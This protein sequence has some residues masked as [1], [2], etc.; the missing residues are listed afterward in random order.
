MWEFHLREI[1]DLESLGRQFDIKVDAQ[2][3]VSILA[4]PVKAGKL[5]IP[6][7]LVVHPMEGCD[8][9]SQGGPGEL[10]FRR[11][12][13]F[14]SGGAGLIWFEA[15]A[16]V[17][18]ARAN[19]RQLWINENSKD[20]FAELV[21]TTKRAAV[22]SMGKDHKPV[23]VLQLTHSGRYSKPEGV[24]CPIAAQCN[25]YLYDPGISDD[26]T[27]VSDDYLD[28]L[29]DSFVE[30]AKLAFEVGFDAVDIK[31]CHGY[32]INELLASYN[33]QGKYGGS[34][35]NRT[36]FLLEVV[37][38]IHNNLG[39]EAVVTTRLGVYDGIQYPYGWG[40]DES[41]YSKPDL[42]EPKK[43][44]K[45]LQQR[46]INLINITLANPYYNPYISRPY[47]NQSDDGHEEHEHPLIGVNRF[48]TL[49]GEIQ[50]SFP[51][52][53]IIGTGYSW[54]R[55]LFANVAAAKKTNGHITMAGMG[56]MAIAYP[57][58]AKDIISNG[59]MNP[60]KVCVCCGAC[61]QIM[62][63]GGTTGCVVRDKEIYGTIFEKCQNKLTD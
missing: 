56:R 50:K 13:R 19:P 32:L 9:D 39:N 58:F 37:G 46:G 24:L 61:T 11:Y 7:S 3:D 8:S 47:N 28:K 43:L 5:N 52:I 20:G 6:N 14:A 62:R 60:E 51:D 44:I 16:V 59:K 29:Q 31:S 18:E 48:V 17:P 38:K 4:E 1:K 49:T 53:A 40:V 36:R 35:E 34:F 15:A 21:K 10:T 22:E 30:A 27:I 23:L 41:E 33:R 25:P 57:D 45:L 26:S 55:T 2:E 42:T 54:L 63:N 12:K